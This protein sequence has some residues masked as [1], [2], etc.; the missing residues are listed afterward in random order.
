MPI[1]KDDIE[2]TGEDYNV[3]DATSAFLKRWEDPEKV[4]KDDKGAKVEDDETIVDETDDKEETEETQDQ[5]DSEDP[6]EDSDTEDT[7]EKPAAKVAEDDAE[8]SYTVDGVEHKASVKELKRLAGQEASLT[9]KSQEV[10]AKTKEVEDVR[11]LHIAALNTLVQ[12]AEDAYKPYAEIDW[13]VASKEMTPEDFAAVRAEAQNSYA[14]YKFL[15][16]ELGGQMQAVADEST[17]SFQVKSTECIAT[18][19]DPTTGIEGWG[20]PMYNEVRDYAVKSGLKVA[21]FNQITDASAIKLIHKAMSFDNIK[22]VATTKKATSAKKVMKSSGNSTTAK[23]TPSEK[24]AMAK[25]KASGKSEDAA[26]VFL[27]RWESEAD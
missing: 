14:N 3:D 26:N 6:N 23:N 20:E 7:E 17:K 12:R 25:L 5:E 24:S 19:T 9:R 13:L 16:E 27:S 15:T 21:V 18:L 1:R 10:A 22:A 4:S 11:S 2:E 8:V